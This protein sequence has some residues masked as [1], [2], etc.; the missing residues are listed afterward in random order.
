MVEIAGCMC[1]DMV[2]LPGRQEEIV[3]KR[4]LGVIIMV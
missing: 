1:N 4:S 3:W 2:K